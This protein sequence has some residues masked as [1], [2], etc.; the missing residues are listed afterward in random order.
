MMHVYYMHMY[1]ICETCVLQLFYT[2]IMYYCSQY[3]LYVDINT[4]P[5][6][7]NN[8]ASYLQYICGTFS[9][10]TYTETS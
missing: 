5:I 6:Q 7:H 2:C 1:Y 8:I 10:E 3:E 4:T 9:S